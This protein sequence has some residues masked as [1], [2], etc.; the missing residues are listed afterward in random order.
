MSGSPVC[1]EDATFTKGQHNQAKVDNNGALLVNGMLGVGSAAGTQVTASSSGGA[2][3]NNCTLTSAA[4][5]TMYITGFMVTG[6]GAT[7]AS[8]ITVTITGT[9]SGTLNYSLAIPAGA[10]A[11]VT[12]LG[13]TFAVPIAA[14]AT[15]TNIVVNVPSFGAGNTNASASAYG[16]LI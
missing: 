15:N 5:K 11:A 8:V 13:Q 10:T 2:Q 1:I 3:A 12:P 16:I 9:I 4:G 14:S 7:S 6:A